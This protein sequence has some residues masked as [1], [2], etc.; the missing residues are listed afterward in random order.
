MNF[1]STHLRLTVFYVLIAMAVSIS[2]SVAIYNISSDELGRGLGR[3]TRQ[4]RDISI[5][6]SAI[7][8]IPDFE[9]IRLDQLE[10][11]N[12]RLK[13]NLIYFN[14]LI[15]LMSSAAGY[16]LAKKTLDPIEEVIEAQ[17]RFTTDAS[18]ELRTPLTVMRAEIE[19]NLRD[20]KL[21]FADAKKLLKS[22]LEE[23]EKLETLS[24]ALLKFARLEENSFSGEIISIEETVIDAYEKVE[25]LAK[26]KSIEFENELLNLKVRG[27]NKMLTEL[28]VILFDNAIKYSPNKSKI[29]IVMKK[30]GK[31]AE[32]EMKDQG[33]GIKASDLSYIFNRFYRA[34]SSRSKEKV[35][36]YGL[37]LSIAKKIVEMHKGSI[38]V[39]SNP[40]K[41]STFTIKLPLTYGK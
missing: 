35:D 15:L 39:S 8:I 10:E 7:S 32:I 12:N 14:L 23:T 1:K 38:A 24:S 17:K 9:Q 18:H 21:N 16:S 19:V 37:G 2:F 29:N 6:G 3:Q 31:M 25:S 33:I 34:D 5:N 27:D 20:E 28:F 26:K 36:G 13:N 40:G 41:G 11:S 4:L 30:D 22:N